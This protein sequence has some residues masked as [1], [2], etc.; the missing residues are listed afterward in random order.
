M[1]VGGRDFDGSDEVAAAIHAN[2]RRVAVRGLAVPGG[3]GR[4]PCLIGL[5]LSFSALDGRPLR[6]RDLTGRK[7]FSR[8]T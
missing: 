5:A 2:R 6:R 4:F 7:C 3:P 1:R 8:K